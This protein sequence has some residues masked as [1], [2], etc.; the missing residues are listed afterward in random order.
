MQNRSKY[1]NKGALLTSIYSLWWH[2][3]T[4]RYSVRR[5]ILLPYQ[6]QITSLRWDPPDILRL[7]YVSVM[8]VADAL[9]PNRRQ[10][11]CYHRADSTVTITSQEYYNATLALRYN[12]LTHNFG[13]GFRGWQT[14]SF[15]WSLQWRHNER[16][17]VSNHQHHCSLLTRLFGRRSKKTSKLRVTGLYEGN[18]PV[19][20]EFPAQRASN[21]GNVSIWWRHN[22]IDR[23]IVSQQ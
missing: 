2:R 22:G 12:Q 3:T 9:T 6:M 18:S 1:F 23:F 14:R 19:T 11:I 7:V 4:C 13:E 20:C 17:G 15:R 10:T 16:D 21:A 8:V 5:G